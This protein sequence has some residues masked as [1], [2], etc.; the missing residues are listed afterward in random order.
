MVL[1]H[2][3]SAASTAPARC[4]EE[5]KHQL[6]SAL[7]VT[8][9]MNKWHYRDKETHIPIFNLEFPMYLTYMPMDCGR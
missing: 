5:K 3:T 4:I 2:C 9:V 7:V 8:G 1:L 6:L